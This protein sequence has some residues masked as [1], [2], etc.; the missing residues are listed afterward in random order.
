MFHQMSHMNQRLTT[1]GI[2]VAILLFFLYLSH[3]IFF[4]WLFVL[5]IATMVG[6]ALW[7]YYRIAKSNGMHPLAKIGIIGS[8]CYIIAVFLSTQWVGMKPLPIAVLGLTLLVAFVYY[9]IKGKDPFVNLAVTCFA[10]AYLTLPLSFAVD[11]NYFFPAESTQDGRWWLL[12]LFAVTKMT[13]AGAFFVGKQF[14]TKKLAPY[15]SPRKT[16]EGALGGF[17]VAVL[18]SILFYLATNLF[19]HQPPILLTLWQSI[20]LGSLICIAAQFGDLAESLLKRD[21]GVKDSNT[22]LPGLG[23]MLDIVDSLVF[24]VP[25]LYI[26]LIVYY[27]KGL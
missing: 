19:F 16:V 3:T 4:D 23:G 11:I 7:E 25:L 20:W 5:F 8:T 24:T 2:G 10:L 26:F 1:S 6:L 17:L 9:F 27:G 13:D 18:T 22:K 21:V 15:I 12:Y 14:G